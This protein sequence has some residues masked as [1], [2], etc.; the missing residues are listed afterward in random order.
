MALVLI[1]V[2][3]LKAELSGLRMSAAVLKE[4]LEDLREVVMIYDDKTAETKITSASKVQQ[5][6]GDLFDLGSIERLLTI[7]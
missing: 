5:L 6:L 7:H 2:M 1:R 3:Q 4:E